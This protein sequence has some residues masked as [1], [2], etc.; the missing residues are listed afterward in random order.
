MRDKNIK[1][2]HFKVSFRK[3]KNKIWG[4]EN[5][6]GEWIKEN[7]DI[8]KEFYGHFAKLFTTSSPTQ[9]Q[10]EEALREIIPKVSPEMNEYPC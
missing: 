9:A 5:A 8:K 6:Q 3:K 4:I 2:F 1:F 7:E 10:M